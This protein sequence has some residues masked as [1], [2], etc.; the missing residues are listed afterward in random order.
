MVVAQRRLGTLSA[1][2]C[3]RTELVAEASR[4]RTVAVDETHVY[5]G[6]FEV[7][8]GDVFRRNVGLDAPEE[9]LASMLGGISALVVADGQLYWTAHGEL[10]GGNFVVDPTDEPMG[11]VFF[12]PAF[13]SDSEAYFYYDEAQILMLAR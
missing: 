13:A 9:I 2:P 5:W 11:G 4:P 3:G 7:G 1:S 6:T 8:D 12:R 10:P